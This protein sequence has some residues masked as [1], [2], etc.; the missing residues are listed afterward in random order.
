MKKF[1]CTICGYVHEGK[2]VESLRLAVAKA[3]DDSHCYRVHAKGDDGEK[4]NVL[5]FSAS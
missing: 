5:H 1:V 2:S 3:S 4:L